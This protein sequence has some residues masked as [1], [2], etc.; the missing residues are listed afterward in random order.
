MI[1][2]LE[3]GRQLLAWFESARLD[4]RAQIIGDLPV[5]GI[6]HRPSFWFERIPFVMICAFP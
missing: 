1:S 4:L 5:Y 2:Q 3:F 6:P